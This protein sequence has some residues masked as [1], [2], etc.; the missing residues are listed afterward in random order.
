MTHQIG[1]IGAG[2]FG[3][4]HA[5]ALR[6]LDGVRVAAASRNNAAALEDFTREFG[7]Q[8]FTDYRDLLAQS[9]IDAVV[10]ATPHHHHTEIALAA[11]KAGKHILLEK[12]MAP[13]L[14]E[15]DAILQAAQEAGV[16][17]MVGHL[18]RFTHSYRFAKD[19][20]AS[21]EMGR[22]VQGTA[23]MQKFWFEP[24]RRGWHLDRATGGGVWLTVGIHPLDRLTWL[25]DS[26]VAAVS[27]RFGTYFHDMAADDTGMVF[28]RY[29]N[30]A[31]GLVISTGYSVGAPRHTT[32]LT[33]TKGMLTIDYGS[34]VQIGRDDQWQLLPESVP[35]GSWM[36]G[37]LVEE[38]R[39]FLHAVD[40]GSEPAVSGADA[41]H[42]M[43]AAFAAERSSE[44]DR[45]VRLDE[46]AR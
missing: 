10:I 26:P 25:I 33:C 19:L 36:H 27:A 24:N 11:V 32:E 15:C 37:A 44:L 39:A 21:G 2:D 23:A 1:I 31:A 35:S 22:V 17:L 34:G 46:I 4:K 29:E 8:G 18:N 16:T 28:L 41:R 43:A 3:A 42:I 6:E 38:W 45:E 12:P 13:T 9:E 5:S 40:T 14:A 20:I 7:G 30:G